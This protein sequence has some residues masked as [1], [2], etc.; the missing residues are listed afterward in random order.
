MA[1]STY[2]L[3]HFTIHD[4]SKRL[5][6]SSVKFI[7]S[8]HKIKKTQE[9]RVSHYTKGLLLSTQTFSKLYPNFNSVS[10]ISEFFI[11][12]NALRDDIQRLG[13]K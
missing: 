11:C 13:H 5:S 8:P 6:F 3:G 10:C 12:L 1:A 9:Q 7:C 4:L 2:A